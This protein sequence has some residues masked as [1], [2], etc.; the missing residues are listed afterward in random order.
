M[1]QRKLITMKVV[2]DRNRE[3]R[4]MRYVLFALLLTVGCEPLG[5]EYEQQ[6]QVQAQ[7]YM[8][9]LQATCDAYG[10]Q[11]GTNAYAQCVQGLQQN[12][13]K[14]AAY[15][16]RCKSFSSFGREMGLLLLRIPRSPHSNGCE[17]ADG[18]MEIR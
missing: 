18:R 17:A 1:S 9:Q 3:A 2:V 8:S 12:N 13:V 6:R 15:N 11:R 14:A 16:E 7:Q 5:P 4:A 10:Y